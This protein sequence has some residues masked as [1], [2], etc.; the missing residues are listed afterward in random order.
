MQL[1][2][3][4]KRGFTLV[5]L[6]VVIAIIGTLASIVLVSLGSSRQKARIAKSL[7]FASSVHHNLGAYAVGIWDF[8]EGS[9]PTA[10]DAS[11][12]NNNGTLVNNPTW[13]CASVDASYT[14]TGKGCSLEF[15]GGNYINAGNST[16]FDSEGDITLVAWVYWK[17]GTGDQNIVTK[18]SSYEFRVNNGYI[19]YAINPWAWRGGSYARI[20]SNNWHHITIVHKGNGPQKIYVD[21]SE[22]YLAVSGGNVFNNNRIVT[23]GARYD[24]TASF[25]NGLIDDVRI[26]TQSLTQAQVELLYAEGLEK[27]NIA[28]D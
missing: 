23:I 24:G 11:G 18:E 4:F 9:G 14:P 6:L 7:Q 8:D 12:H 3:C 17:G 20:S 28:Q 21:G 25:F 19:N 13:Q 22:K 1:K 2:S 27:Y 10:N 26:Y 16:A 15:G 5:E